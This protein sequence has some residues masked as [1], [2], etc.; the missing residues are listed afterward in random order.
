MKILQ[1]ENKAA[2]LKLTEQVDKWSMDELCQEIERVYGAQAHASGADFGEITNCIEAAADTL[3]I[4][5]HSPGGS[6][7]DGYRLFNSITA[8]RARGVHVTAHVTLAAS[9]ASVIAMAADRIHMRKGAR[10]MI[11]EASAGSHG[12]A[13]EHRNRAELL[14]SI[15]D[16]IAGIYAQRTGIPQDEIRA[17]MKKET[18]MNGEQAVALKFIADATKTKEANHKPGSNCANCQ[19]FTAATGAC[20]LFPGFSVPA[21]AWCSAWAKKA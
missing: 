1:I 9:M 16:E 6:V 3:E 8:L 19:F 17:S 12:N 2:K 13:A 4:E 14:E 15:S 21:A 5:I 18:W 11:H 10:M 7:L 20:T